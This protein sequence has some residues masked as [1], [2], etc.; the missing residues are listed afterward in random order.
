MPTC[1]SP[2]PIVEGC[3]SELPS[4]QSEA[5][6][7]QRPRSSRCNR[8][9]DQRLY[10]VGR[11]CPLPEEDDFWVV[12]PFATAHQRTRR[13]AGRHAGKDLQYVICLGPPL[14]RIVIP[15]LRSFQSQPCDK[16]TELAELD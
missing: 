13:G 11:R 6:D 5:N 16:I 12:F 7:N 14:T 15:Q 9:T 10:L 2:E 1:Q 4:A 8:F 3:R